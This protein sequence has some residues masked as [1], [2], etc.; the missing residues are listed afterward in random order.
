MQNNIISAGLVYFYLCGALKDD[1]IALEAVDSYRNLP[2]GF[3]DNI[4]RRLSNKEDVPD[5]V[6]IFGII[7]DPKKVDNISTIIRSGFDSN[8]SNI[9]NGKRI[10]KTN[11]Q[12]DHLGNTYFKIIQEF[13]LEEQGHFPYVLNREG[14][15][16]N[17]NCIWCSNAA[18]SKIH[19]LADSALTIWLEN[20]VPTIVGK[21]LMLRSFFM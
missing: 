4:R 19:G 15:E 13:F 18:E 8:A 20:E 21:Q 17:V 16:W 9:L 10:K 12:L 1:L 7:G 5:V 2:E 11:L 14:E 3:Y 6:H